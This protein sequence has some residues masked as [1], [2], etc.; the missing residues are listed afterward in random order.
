MP[1]WLDTAYSSYS[2]PGE[3]MSGPHTHVHM[4]VHVCAHTHTHRFV[5]YMYSSHYEMS[6]W[7]E[8]ITMYCFL[9]GKPR[10]QRL[11]TRI[12]TTKM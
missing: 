5:N 2:V 11:I 8:S 12:T 6:S 10:A 1:E 7:E 4:H 9:L 3:E